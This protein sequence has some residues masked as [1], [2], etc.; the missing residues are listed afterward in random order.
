MTTNPLLN[1]GHDILPV[2]IAQFA[3]DASSAVVRG[4]DRARRRPASSLQLP[5]PADEGG[6][7][8]ATMY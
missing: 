6:A 8:R 1:P 2:L 5:E 4:T 7:A 3:A